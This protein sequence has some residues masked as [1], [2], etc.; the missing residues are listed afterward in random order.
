MECEKPKQR[1]KK[2][3]KSHESDSLE[4]SSSLDSFEVDLKELEDLCIAMKPDSPIETLEV[5]NEMNKQ[6]T[7]ENINS[8]TEQEESIE[9]IQPSAPLEDISK[10]NIFS[11]PLVN[12][13]LYPDLK[14]AEVATVS[15]E[16]TLSP[17]IMK[18]FTQH[19]LESLYKINELDQVYRFEEEFV[20]RE[21]KDTSLQE[22]P[23]Y[24]LLKKYARSRSRF[25]KNTNDAECTMQN[26]EGNYKKI[27]KIEHRQA[28]NNGF[29]TCG[30]VLYASHSYKFA[31]FCDDAY[32]EMDQSMRNLQVMT[33]I[34]HVK[35][36]Q[37][38]ALF[39][40]QI[41]QMINELINADVFKHISND[42]PIALNQQIEN[43]DLRLK[44]TDLRIYV[45]ILFKFLREMPQEK[46][47]ELDIQNWIKQLIS[48]QLRIATWEDH[49]FIL[50]H[51]LRCVDGVG[52]WASS[53]VQIPSVEDESFKYELLGSPDIH[54]CISILQI[55][56]MP[57][58]KRLV[59]LEDHLKDVISTKNKSEKDLWILVDSDGEE[60]SSSTE[61]CSK[62]RESDIVALF[63]Q[64]PWEFVFKTMC[65]AQKVGDSYEIDLE[66][67]SFG[68]HVI[69]VIA[70]TSRFLAILKIGLFDLTDRHKQFAKRLG[71][72]IKETLFYLRDIIRIY[73]KSSSY[74][75]PEEYQRIQVEYDELLIRSACFIYEIKKLS[76]FQYLADFPY[77][78]VTTKAL[79]N[80][81][82]CLH[83][84]DFKPRYADSSPLKFDNEFINKFNH[85]IAMD[86]LFFLL[87]TF[88]KMSEGKGKEDLEFLNFICRDL[89]H[90]GFINEYTKD[91]CYNTVK[92]LVA[93]ITN[94]FPEIVGDIIHFI[95]NNLASIG[96]LNTYILK[97][98]PIHKW[99]PTQKDLELFSSWLLNYDFDTV[100]SS[101]ARFIIA[102]INWNFDHEN[103]L[104]LPHEIHVRMAHLICEVYLKYVG[105]SIKSDFNETKFLGKVTK[106]SSKKDK[107][108]VWCWSMI[109][110][111]RLHQIDINPSAV[112]KN[113]NTL[114]L[115]P[116]FEELNVVYQG[117]NDN[118]PLAIYISF[119]IS[120][121]GHSV[122]QICHRGFEQ[123]KQLLIDHRYPKVIRCLELIVP[124]FMEC[125]QSLFQ[126][127]TYVN[128][129][130]TLIKAD[131]TNGIVSKDKNDNKVTI[132]KLFGNM[133]L[134]Q[135]NSY[136]KY[137]W[138]SPHDITYLWINSILKIKNW[139]KDER[140]LWILELIC[141]F[142][143]PF[144][145][146]LHMVKEVLRSHVQTIAVTKV[147]KSSGLLSL[148]MSE[149]LDIL[150][151][152]VFET[153][154]LS[155][156]ILECEHENIEVNTG[157][158]NDLIY[159]LSVQND[160][161][162][163]N[164]HKSVLSTKQLTSFP[165]RSLV[166][167]KLAKLICKCSTNNFIY[168]II[169]QQFFTL[170]FS[171]VFIDISN[172]SRA[173]Q[174]K[175]YDLDI[176][177]MKKL[178]RKLE[179]SEKYHSD[180]ATNESSGDTSQFHTNL[181]KIFKTFLLW[182]EENQLN[183]MMQKNIILPPLYEGQKLKLIFQGNRTH[184]TEYIDIMELRRVQKTN[185]DWW[186]KY[187]MRTN[188]AIT[189]DDFND[190]KECD[191]IQE[192]ANKMCERLK[193]SGKLTK[194]PPEFVRKSL[195][196]GK[197]D[198]SKDTLK[199]FR[200]ETKLLR[201]CA[202]QF[203]MTANEHK[204]VDAVYRDSV[205]YAFTNESTFRMKSVQCSR[206]TE[207]SCSGFKMMKVEFSE[208]KSNDAIRMKLED[209]RDYFRKLVAKELG[210]ADMRITDASFCLQNIVQQLI[211][212]SYDSTKREKV[213]KLSTS[214]FY[215][216]LD[217]IDTELQEYPI[218]NEFYSN[219]VAKLGSFIQQ[220]DS[221][222]ML[223]VL[224]LVLQKPIAI[225]LFTDIFAPSMSS[226][227][228][229]ISL[230]ECL[231]NLYAKNYEPQILFVLV[232]KFDIPTWLQAHRPKLVEVS[233]LI[234]LIFRGLELWTIE[235]SELLQDV[236]RCHLVHLFMYRFPEHY[237]EILQCIL[238]EFSQQRLRPC[239]LLDILNAFYQKVG[240]N[241]MDT[242]MSIG[243]MKDEMRILAA[244][245]NLL[246]YNELHSTAL[247]LN[248]YFYNERLQHGLHGN[249]PKFA[250]YCDVLSILFGTIGHCVI[251][252]AIK[253]F[254]EAS[255]DYL[256]NELYPC[257]SN[258]Y[259]PMLVPLYYS[260]TVKDGPANWIQQLSTGNTILQPWSNVHTENAEKF[261]RTY[262]MCIQ[263]MFDM[264][265]G[266]NLLIQH[267]FTWYIEY[268]AN[269]TTPKHVL[270]PI[271]LLLTK[272]PFERFLPTLQHMEGFNRVLMDFV[273][274][275]HTFL[276]NIFLRISWTQWLSVQLPTLDYTTSQRT[277]AILLTTIIKLS[278]EPKVR[279]SIR[280]LQLLQDAV[281]YNWM[282]LDYK[283]VENVLDWFVMS[284]EPSVIL[285]IPSE[286]E[287]VDLN[288]HML[289]QT[290][291]GMR[292]SQNQAQNVQQTYLTAK[293][294]AY[295]RSV[296]RLL[297]SCDA[298]LHQLIITENGKQMINEA[299]IEF[300]NLI[301]SVVTDEMEATNLV[302]TITDNMSVP[303]NTANLFVGG[304]QAWQNATKIGSLTL[305]CFINALKIQKYW[306]LQMFQVLESS[307]LNYMRMSESVPSHKPSWL[308]ALER[309]PLRINYD[310]N[311]LIDRELYLS[312]HFLS[313]TKMSSSVNDNDRLEYLIDLQ[314]KLSSQKTTEQTEAGYCLL[315]CF[316]LMSYGYVLKSYCN[317]EKQLRIVA[318]YLQV[319]YSQNEGWGDGLLGA[320]G[321]KK[322]PQTNEKKIL[323]RCFACGALALIGT[324]I[325]F[326]S[327]TNDLKTFLNQKKF[328]DIKMK[329]LQ[330]I[331]L[332]ENKRG[333]ICIDFID[334]MS[335]VMRIF[336]S[337]SYFNNIDKLYC[338]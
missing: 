55:L 1:R 144:S 161:T 162:L 93:D 261:I 203:T 158:W 75:D 155:L 242:E 102:S 53:F 66:K 262:A 97:S 287:T 22:H 316:L 237:G 31:L 236:L 164:I 129:L 25:M 154:I 149:E 232:S 120:K 38:C 269:K 5:T 318:K 212:M 104:F 117:A 122:P 81:Y 323:M 206:P 99:K 146:T 286:H 276:G 279:E 281:K 272:L 26:L 124:L 9:C 121:Y 160:S 225:N 233:E 95:K 135:L 145:D 204:A 289:L 305:C 221:N 68:H 89:I 119:L 54:H 48:L 71:K 91:F 185:C 64:I 187:C 234:K 277:M 210:E 296:V 207:N 88:A 270:A 247:M 90:I 216:L 292:L 138:T 50:F 114:N 4:C 12:E 15:F 241:K 258:M 311:V 244:K 325:E 227:A 177:L 42:S 284:A 73:Q 3:S 201:K 157:Y 23:L 171:R 127:E 103:Q 190:V 21:L 109:S 37:E 36:S 214:L 167:Y 245:Q 133:I 246:Q 106:N 332:I 291:S 140:M 141:Q 202:H 166:I 19:Q 257:I 302:V 265:P 101:T 98:L 92:D 299:F 150:Y 174:E 168:P 2:K 56:L 107:F 60:G 266:S 69:K 260:Q 30:R 315:W 85:D 304:I 268:F 41:E 173:V 74:K 39:H 259:A 235:N 219:A 183:S 179:E 148:V 143:Y 67:V 322:D 77:E 301:D 330:A 182:L 309:L 61:D 28:S 63:D 283:D 196:M 337:D 79:W 243:R 170:Y 271:Q 333:T 253:A 267:L 65:F 303:E 326:E 238:T 224:K 35:F 32:S 319:T 111:L 16:K 94:K 27:W 295:V 142:S 306:T 96:S 29:C 273:P 33:S 80:L 169:C 334:V 11:S 300:L 230:Y 338:W 297:K 186:L 43:Y 222:E 59:F 151:S 128:I 110:L 147:P 139:H 86:D 126:C 195:Y 176:A 231:V 254:P 7:E 198:L 184:W 136:Q 250:K 14:L 274:D 51:I 72:L 116:E 132:L 200:N 256:V 18:P 209:N 282:I 112:I 317:A 228:I 17:S 156:L 211:Q 255:A 84:G 57:I 49:V 308:N 331:S 152:P 249:Y 263:Y 239:I 172:D 220:N 70:F 20:E 44:V 285:K 191:S 163:E 310:L 115:I 312:V 40:R 293:R 193:S 275:C 87:H 180:I 181:S 199:L 82:Y 324:N 217:D 264:L 113:P 159:Q 118:K 8:E 314:T 290:V 329:G 218:T 105:E 134:N 100:E 24:I 62:L 123:L 251:S 215:E 288:I 178:K 213:L 76:L 194:P 321:L 252:A 188:L 47:L 125:V 328:T 307:L 45:S 137:G 336:Y 130:E 83:S 108:S 13:N 313:I 6:E 226:P 175:F 229:F 131:K 197:I 189:S 52:N 298:K 335:K 223:K 46:Q 34:N 153:P 327:A 78:L 192:I 240:C 280:I 205:R 58:H 294:M 320:I 10:P 165:I 248:H 208:M 278:F